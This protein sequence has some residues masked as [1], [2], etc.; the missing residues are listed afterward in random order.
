M[1]EQAPDRV[2]DVPP[3]PDQGPVPCAPRDVT[4]SAFVEAFGGVRGLVDS[5]LPATVFV[6]VR[7]FTHALSPAL[8]AAV[9]VGV[10]VLVLRRVR[11]ESLQQ[12]ASGF[13][14]LA[15]AVVFAR[16]TGSGE[17][18]FLPGI[19]T[20]ALTG[21]AFVVSLLVR[22]PAVGLAL[23]AFDPAYARWAEHPPLV[24]AVRLATA[25]WALTFFIR[26]GVAYGVYRRAGDND[27]ALLIVI[28]VVKWPLIVIAALLTVALVR[29][30]GHPPAPVEP[31]EPA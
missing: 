19:L 15:I 8:Y 21:V 29:G 2:P 25:F 7:L 23:G 17:G 22:R 6:L 3:D 31:G 12:A 30:A 24:R 27:G 5:A 14:G 18:F 26:S 13:F 10:A 20:T 9:G 11:G 28:N 16:A 1:P 4:T